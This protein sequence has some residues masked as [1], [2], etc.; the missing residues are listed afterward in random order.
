M[1]K[2]GRGLCSNGLGVR[3]KPIF[4]INAASDARASVAVHVENDIFMV[5][6]FEMEMVLS[7]EESR[8]VGTCE[9]ATGLH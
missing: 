2:E 3:Y 9:L 5:G 8:V 7:A 6:E 1:V 4:S